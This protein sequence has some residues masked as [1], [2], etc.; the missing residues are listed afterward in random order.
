MLRT[1][2]TTGCILLLTTACGQTAST[3]SL[4]PAEAMGVEVVVERPHDAIAYTQGLELDGDTLYESTGLPGQSS[5]REV[6]RVTGDVKRLEPLDDDYFG[7]GIAVVDDR[8]VQLT[9]QNGVA[10]VYSIPDL[11]QTATFTY[12]GEGWGL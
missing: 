9:W 8:I 1:A 6:D 12:E 5:L 11:G 4:A 2:F 3:S 7:E 10:L